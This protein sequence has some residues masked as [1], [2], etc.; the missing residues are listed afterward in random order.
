M[1]RGSQ[2]WSARTVARLR[3]VLAIMGRNREA[4]IGAVIVAVFLLT[5]IVVGVATALGI[6]VTPYGPVQTDTG[7]KL[8]PPSLSHLFGTDLLGRDVFSRIIV[9]TPNDVSVGVGVVAFALV[10]GLIIGSIAAVK[11]GLLDE[12][13]MRFTDVVFALPALVIA[14]VIAVALGP[15]VTNMMIALMIIWWPPHARLA[16]GEALKVSHQN[17]IRSARLAGLG[18]WKIIFRHVIPNIFVI[19]LVYATLD[20]GTVILV[21]AGL[22]YLGLSVKPPAPDWGE[23]VSAFQDYLITA[24]WLPI[25][26]GLIISIGVIGFSLLGDGIRDALEAG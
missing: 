12:L 25:V 17:Y 10:V 20:V 21:Y 8:A 3:S 19:M 13:L 7:P 1:E 15:G 11:G 16:R 23:M 9:A 6:T 24:P 14:M 22:S 2:I 4:K 5:A 26:P 18:T